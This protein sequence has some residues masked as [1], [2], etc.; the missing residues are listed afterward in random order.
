MCT[1]RE[2]GERGT[3]TPR[4]AKERRRRLASVST[5]EPC[6][7]FHA[8]LAVMRRGGHAV[9]RKLAGAASV[10]SGRQEAMHT[11]ERSGHWI[12][13]LGLGS[14]G[15]CCLFASVASAE[16]GTAAATRELGC[17]EPNSAQDLEAARVAFRAGQTAFSEGGY[18]R[19]VELWDQA[20]RDDCTA[21]A[22]LLNLAMAQEL[23]G[24][25]NDAIQTLTLFNRRSPGSA[26]VEANVKRIQRLER[27][28]AENDRERARRDRA[29]GS[30]VDRPIRLDDAVGLSLP[31]VVGVTGGAVAVVGAA[32]FVEG[33]VSASS[34]EERCGASRAAC[35]GVG[36]L[37]E[38]ERGRARAEVGGWLAGAGLA[39]AAGGMLWHFLTR[40][41]RPLDQVSS[42]ARVS[43]TAARGAG[44]LWTETF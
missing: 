35:D 15:V 41:E 38:G 24:R 14:I 44:L 17:T 42:S 27:A 26:Y 36:G 25:P 33:R 29:M 16:P 13:R 6:G 7:C 23:L 32:L 11:V 31:L 5:L 30:P 28:A 2:I 4:W 3:P 21:P 40:P 10:W 9:T 34:A 12:R 39:T 37:V 22:L 43:L 18:A 8:A 20:Y 19:A 1:E